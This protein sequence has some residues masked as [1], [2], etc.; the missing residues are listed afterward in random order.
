MKTA[1]TITL[2]GCLAIAGVLTPVQAEIV[3]IDEARTVADNWITV[4]IELR[5]AWGDYETAALAEVRE[6]RRGERVLGYYCQVEPEGFVVV[7]LVRGLAPVKAYSETCGLDPQSDEDLAD[8]IKV[9][10]TRV[11]DAIEA[12]LGDVRLVSTDDV[13]QILDTDYRQAWDELGGDSLSGRDGEFGQLR[14]DYQEGQIMLSTIWHQGHPYN[15]QCPWEDCPDDPDGR[16]VVGCVATAGAQVMRYWYWPPYGSGGSYGDTYDWPNIPDELT[17]S[18]PQVEI[19]AV[20]ELCHE[21]GTASGMDYGC[22]RSGA[23]LTCSWPPDC[24]SLEKAFDDHFRY[25]FGIG[26]TY[27]DDYDSPADWFERLKYDLNRNWP[28]VYGIPGHAVVADG[29]MEAGSDPLLRFYHINYGWGRSESCNG[30]CNT[31]YLVDEI[32]GGNPDDELMLVNIRPIQS[33]G[34]NPAGSYPAPEFPYRYFDRDAAGGN[35]IFGA[36][37]FLQ[38]LPGITVT[39]ISST[40]D[41]IRFYGTSEANTRM[42]TRGDPSV[43]ILIRDG[44]VKLSRDG[45]IVFP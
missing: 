34:P 24:D 40:G 16:T 33:V 7:S 18:S 11:L 20:A 29:W 27:R 4:I 6:F 3:T 35:V 17:G 1:K 28:V 41:S 19:D 45:S 31:W 13:V 30:P 42:F 10:M 26:H 32:Y 22:D 14:M 36:G 39:C 12:L 37:H 2:I 25:H 15:A 44:C 8:F 5:G 21:V 38:F 43:G 23:H 9:G